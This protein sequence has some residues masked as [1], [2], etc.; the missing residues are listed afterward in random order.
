MKIL[1]DD[2]D[3]GI[4]MREWLEEEGPTDPAPAATGTDDAKAER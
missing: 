1:E 2:E 4:P 3:I